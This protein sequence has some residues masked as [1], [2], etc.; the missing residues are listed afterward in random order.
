MTM[1]PAPRRLG[2]VTVLALHEAL[3]E[4]VLRIDGGSMDIIVPEC[5]ILPLGFDHVDPTLTLTP[6]P[7]PI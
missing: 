3:L 5:D 1:G 2:E 4:K 7:T 6:T